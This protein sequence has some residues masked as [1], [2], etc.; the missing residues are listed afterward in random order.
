[1][2]N[3][4]DIDVY[5]DKGTD[6][7]YTVNTVSS[8]VDFLKNNNITDIKISYLR[9]FVRITYIGYKLDTEELLKNE[10][11]GYIGMY[12]IRMTRFAPKDPAKVYINKRKY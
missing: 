12:N 9:C 2:T 1:M 11:D 4:Y 7:M 3:R 10:S 5:S 8:I 6:S